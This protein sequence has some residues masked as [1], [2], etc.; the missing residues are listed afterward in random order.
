[1][2]AKNKNDDTAEKFDRLTVLLKDI[3]PERVRMVLMKEETLT[4][5][6]TAHDKSEMQ[7]VAK[8]CGLT[9]TEYLTRLHTFASRQFIKG[10]ATIARRTPSKAK[11]H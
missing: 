2:K 3:P 5:R 9:L 4:I 8:A 11:E 6:V 7:R 1:M 10:D